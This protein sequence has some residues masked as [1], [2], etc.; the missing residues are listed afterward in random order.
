MRSIRL[1]SLSVAAAALGLLL[2]SCG[3]KGDDV[4]A[5]N[6][7]DANDIELDVGTEDPPTTDV[8][9]DVAEVEGDDEGEDPVLGDE[10]PD[11][12][13]DDG[14]TTATV[15]AGGE[16]PEESAAPPNSNGAASGTDTSGSGTS[17][18]ATDGDG[19]A[20]GSNGAGT[21]GTGGEGGR[22]E[23][24]ANPGAD[25]DDEANEGDITNDPAAIDRIDK[26]F[27]ATP[28]TD[29]LSGSEVELADQL[30]AGDQNVLLW[31]WEPGSGASAAEADVVQRL[32]EQ[33]IASIEIIAIGIGGDAESAKE[34]PAESGLSGV[35]IVWDG[36]TRNA[37]Q[38]Q[39]T[40]LPSAVLLDP[41]GD[42]IGRWTTLSPEVFQLIGLLSA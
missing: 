11:A 38:Y 6:L 13:V 27:P 2:A 5:T 21:T 22:T 24:N 31:F 28:V 29:V 15:I 12:G 41:R 18:A 4:R 36:T 9:P 19:T 26:G 25:G 16:Q 17:T 37:E 33:D 7:E 35:S 8:A 3:S 34:F 14:Q 1:A 30:E 23:D 39:V 32:A 10:Q 20:V 40:A 42:I